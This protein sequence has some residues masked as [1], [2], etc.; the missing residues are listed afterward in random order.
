MGTPGLAVSLPELRRG[1]EGET[2]ERRDPGNNIDSPCWVKSASYL[3]FEPQAGHRL[4]WWY[5]YERCWV[6]ERGEG[7]REVARSLT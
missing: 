2:E 5:Y 3:T 1:E 4:H 7:G 6:V